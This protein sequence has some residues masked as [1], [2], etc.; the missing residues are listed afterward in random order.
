MVVALVSIMVDVGASNKALRWTFENHVEGEVSN[1]LDMRLDALLSAL[2]FEDGALKLPRPLNDPRYDDLAGGAYWQVFSNGDSIMQSPSLWTQ[3]LDDSQATEEEGGAYELRWPDKSLVYA[4]ERDV[5]IDDGGRP[6]KFRLAVGIDHSIIDSIDDRFAHDS[7][8]ALGALSSILLLGS[9]AQIA[10][11]LR[12]FRKLSENI[13][14]IKSGKATKLKANVPKELAPFVCEFNTLLVHQTD[15]IRRSRERAGALAHGLKT[16]ITIL[17]G[18][19]EK[20]DEQGLGD[21]A[22]RLRE[23]LGVINKHVG[24]ELARARA[25]GISNASELATDAHGSVDRLI[26]LI[27]R[28]PRGSALSIVNAIPQGLHLAIDSDDFG[29]IMGNLLDN[30]R[31]FAVSQ[32]IVSSEAHNDQSIIYVEDDGSGMAASL[33]ETLLQRGERADESVEGHGLGYSI[34]LDLLSEYG[35]R[36]VFDD[37]KGSGCKVGFSLRSVS[38]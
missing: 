32:I 3:S 15:M 7:R 18:E 19:A 37:V 6:R 11:V 21:V 17:Y 9:L 30:A 16:P 35:S 13:R 20:L 14:D 29:E 1:E 10:I 5:V 25:H 8:I 24:R 12:P 26:K 4:K 33:R 2:R 23:H 38:P 27:S 22:A 36:L 31:K 28:M 34:V